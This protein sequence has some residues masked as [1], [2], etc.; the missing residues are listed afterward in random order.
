MTP[1]GEDCFYF[2]ILCSILSNVKAN[3]TMRKE[4]FPS[5]GDAMLDMIR[6]P[7]PAIVTRGR[8]RF[9]LLQGSQLEASDWL[10]PAQ[11]LLYYQQNAS[12]PWLGELCG[13]RLLDPCEHQCDPETGQCLCL[14][15]YMK[16]PVHK[17][18]CIRSEWGPNQGPWPYTIFQRGFDLVM[19]EQPSDRIFSV[20]H[21]QTFSR[22]SDYVVQRRAGPQSSIKMAALVK[23][24]LICSRGHR[25]R[26]Y[27]TRH[28]SG[29]F[30]IRSH[31]R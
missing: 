28:R 5:L 12:G 31:K 23:R 2:L 19:G 29:S 7:P 14:D 16:D 25:G 30:S 24:L 6:A 3:R 17:H 11:I 10:N 15:G 27:V 26:V 22:R 21:L 18:L 13:R 4:D 9:I 20:F 1:C 8:S